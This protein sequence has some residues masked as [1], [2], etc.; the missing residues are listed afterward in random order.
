MAIQRTASGSTVDRKWWTSHHIRT[1]SYHLVPS[2][3]IALSGLLLGLSGVSGLQGR[4]DS[5]SW[6]SVSNVFIGHLRGWQTARPQ[7]SSG[8][9]YAPEWGLKLFVVPWSKILGVSSNCPHHQFIFSVREING[10]GL[11]LSFLRR[12]WRGTSWVQH[13]PNCF[14]WSDAVSLLLE[15]DSVKVLYH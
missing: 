2:S 14:G 4:V 13:P 10:S 6:Y 5:S 15:H 3:A 1:T 9:R 12:S 7:T 11:P 8:F